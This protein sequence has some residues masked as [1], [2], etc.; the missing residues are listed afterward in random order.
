MAIIAVVNQKGGVG[1]STIAVALAAELQSRGQSVLLA[2][3]DPQASAQAWGAVAA[4]AGN[5]AP[6]VVGVREGFYRADQL[7]R[8]AKNYSWTIV[9]TPPHSG[10]IMRA[11]LA[12][13]N[14]VLLPCG[15]GAFDAWSLGETLDILGEAKRAKPRLKSAIVLNRVQRRTALSTGA[16][17]A[18][19]DSGVSILK[20]ELGMRVAYAEAVPAGQGPT[21]YAPSSRAAD[22]VRALTDEVLRLAGKNVGGKRGQR[23]KR[24]GKRGK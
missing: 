2:D 16:R 9:D 7:P 23:K 20:S 24:G 17:A 21:T 12:V 13:A 18:L 19:A 3:A 6:T 10:P 14:V 22:E 11:A 15:P 1:K 4:E 5:G 8:L